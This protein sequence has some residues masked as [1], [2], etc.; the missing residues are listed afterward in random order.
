MSTKMWWLME[1]KILHGVTKMCY[2]GYN[3][4]YQGL[5]YIKEVVHCFLSISS[6]LRDPELCY[7]SGTRVLTRQ[8]QVKSHPENH[9]D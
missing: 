9:T 4:K 8:Y 7:K 3:K 1:D 5:I 6:G 2:I